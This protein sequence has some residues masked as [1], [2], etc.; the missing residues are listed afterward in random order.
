MLK[1]LQLLIFLL[2]ILIVSIMA[3][4]LQVTY[5]KKYPSQKEGKVKAY[6]HF[7]LNNVIMIRDAKVIDGQY[8][9]FVG[10]PSIKVKEEW[11][12]ICFPITK[13]LRSH[14]TDSILNDK[15]SSLETSKQKVD[16]TEIKIYRIKDAKGKVKAF[17]SITLNKV[18]VIKEIKIIEGSKGLFI[19]W[20]SYKK[21]GKYKTV[22]YPVKQKKEIEQLILKKY[23][24]D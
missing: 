9:K 13:D 14:I 23:N 7:K 17:C 21:S 22:V 12:D 1:K 19:G 11:K 18:F 16:V 24:Q 5:V 3:Q 2:F 6:V 15:F 4:D 10:M 20:P 8:G